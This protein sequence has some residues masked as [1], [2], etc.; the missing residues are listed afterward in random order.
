MVCS[1]IALFIIGDWYEDHTP[2]Y[3]TTTYVIAAASAVIA[4]VFIM[5]SAV[6]GK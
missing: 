6:C 5:L 2:A 1:A 3:S 4:A